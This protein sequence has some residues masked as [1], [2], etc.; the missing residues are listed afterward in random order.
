MSWHASTDVMK[1]LSRASTATLTTQ[2]LKRG[3]RSRF[4]HGPAPIVPGRRMIGPARTLR[5]APMRED[6]DTLASLASRSN[7][8]R[9]VIEDVAPGE[10]LVID[11][12]GST[13]AGTLGDILARRLQ[14][15]GAAGIVTDGAVRDAPSI[16]ELAIPSYAAARCANP[17]VGAFHAADFDVPIG[18]GGVLVEVGDAVVGDDEGVVVVPSHLVA[19]VAEDANAQELRETFVHERVEAGASVFDVYPMNEE[20]ERAYEAWSQRRAE[21]EDH[22]SPENDGGS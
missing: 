6:L 20:T 2:L 3:F 5:F 12:M 1:W 4:L 22:D 18:C 21:S 19:E 8:Q 10:V 15:R 14:R 7:P 9:A 13:Q 17:S 16:A 11:A